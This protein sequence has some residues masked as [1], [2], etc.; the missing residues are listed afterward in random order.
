MKNNIRYQ[1]LIAGGIYLVIDPAMARDLLIQKLDTA[2][3]S[4]RLCAVQ[5]WDNWSQVTTSHQDLIEDIRTRCHRH[6]VVLLLNNRWDWLSN[7]DLDGVHF[8]TLPDDL[9]MIRTKVGRDFIIGL[10]LG[11]DLELLSDT[12]NIPIDYLSFCSMFPSSSASNCEIVRPEV[13]LQAKRQVSCPIF[14]AGGINSQTVSSL[15]PLNFEGLA[16]ISGIMSEDDPKSAT[17]I[18]YQEFLKIN[19]KHESITNR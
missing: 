16:I 7:K 19:P 9:A 17:E 2:L 11:N 3:H 12:K 5:L 10:T 1:K 8:D 4:G 13:V 6:E 15:K 18:L 14:L